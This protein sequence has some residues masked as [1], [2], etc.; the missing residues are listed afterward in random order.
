MKA[1]YLKPG[2]PAEVIDVSDDPRELST[3]V[4][5]YLEQLGLEYTM[6]GGTSLIVNAGGVRLKLQ[7]NFRIH[8]E[9]YGDVRGCVPIVG[10]ALLLKYDSEGELSDIGDDDLAR[11]QEACER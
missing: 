9:V 7:P 4:G 3:L 10:P 1:Y 2:Q 11:F 6:K 5:G 8:M